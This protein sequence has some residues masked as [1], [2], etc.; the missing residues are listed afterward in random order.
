MNSAYRASIK[1]A[2]SA[3][4]MLLL[5]FAANAQTFSDSLTSPLNS[6]YWTFVATTPGMYSGST[7]AAGLHVAKTPGFTGPGGL[8]NVGAHLNLAA[9]GG[10]IAGDF[11]VQV[12]FSNAAI[13]G[14][15]TNQVELQTFYQNGSL[16]IDSLDNTGGINAH[17]FNGSI[18]P[19]YFGA[20]TSGLFD[21]ARVGSII[22]GSYNGTVLFSESNTSALT[23]VDA[24]LQNNGTNDDISVT[25]KD[26]SISG[27]NVP[28]ATP[29]PGSVALISGLAVTGLAALRRKNRRK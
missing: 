5:P 29:E 26:F 24:I 9:L 2:L 1:T 4:G 15:I 21:I 25:L 13:N 7:S 20:T 8:Q 11:D 10:A 6:T 12:K 3:A 23:G 28:A 16:F 17:V 19:R 27:L 18:Q 14:G 22:T